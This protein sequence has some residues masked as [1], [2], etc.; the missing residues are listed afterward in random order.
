MNPFIRSDQYNFIKKQTQA[1]VNGHATVNDRGVLNAL[2]ALS[3]EKV[4]GLFEEST[5]AQKNLLK[6]I[7]EIKEKLEAESFLETLKPYVIPFKEIS[8]TAIK[9]IFPKAKK[10]K[11]P[12]LENIDFKELSYLGWLDK[13]SN[14]KFLV[15]EY[16]NKLVGI[17][18]G[19]KNSNKK[20]ICA[21]CNRT[22]EIGMFT[23]SVKGM[24]QDAF[25]TRGNYIC[26]DSQKCNENIISLDKLNKFVELIENK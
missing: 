21:L 4:L 5:E 14:K 11:I 1:L 12:S 15:I 18:G 10:L 24:T 6:A 20:G 16:K 23:S 22:E 9:K 3:L 19:Y 8:E 25:I 26:Q 2:R 13:G 17:S 7:V